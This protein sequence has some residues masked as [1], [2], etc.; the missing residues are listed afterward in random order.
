MSRAAVGLGG[1]M[2]VG[3]GGRLGVDGIDR[4]ASRWL[5]RDQGRVSA[6]IRKVCGLFCGSGGDGLMGLVET[7]E[8]MSRSNGALSGQRRHGRACRLDRSGHVV[9]GRLVDMMVADEVAGESAKVGR[10]RHVVDVA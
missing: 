10:G 3:V 5:A 1:G 4:R 7:G 6:V 2:L 9:D 8:D